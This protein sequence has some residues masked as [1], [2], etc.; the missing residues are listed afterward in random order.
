MQHKTSELTGGYLD[1]AV[2]LAEGLQPRLH[3]FAPDAALL[4]HVRTAHED[5]P[6]QIYSRLFC[7]STNWDRG[8]PIIERERIALNPPGNHPSDQWWAGFNVQAGD[9]PGIYMD[10]DAFGPTPLIA[11]MRAFVR[12][13]FGETVELP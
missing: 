12:R 3:R 6:T 13:R 5:E 9:G 11:A 8:G 2:A 4:C 10:D 1:F 7:P